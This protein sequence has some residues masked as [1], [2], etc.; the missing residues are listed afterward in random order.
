MY[1][2]DFDAMMRMA[3]K[4]RDNYGNKFTYTLIDK[5]TI[6]KKRINYGIVGGILLAM[7]LYVYYL[8]KKKVF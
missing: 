1:K 7:T 6:L 5:R 4:S 2:D 3:N 8:K